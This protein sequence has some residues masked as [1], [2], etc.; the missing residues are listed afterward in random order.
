M[1]SGE[2]ESHGEEEKWEAKRSLLKFVTVRLPFS[3]DDMGYL[4]FF[5]FFVL[6]TIATITNQSRIKRILTRR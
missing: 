1:L 3:S 4:H 2:Y 5:Q 6:S